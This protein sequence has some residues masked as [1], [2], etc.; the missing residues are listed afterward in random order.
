MNKH[1]ASKIIDT[2]EMY[3]LLK[4]RDR[5][6]LSRSDYAPMVLRATVGRMGTN[7]IGSRIAKLDLFLLLM[8]FRIMW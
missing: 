3:H 4:I 2:F 7:S 8:W 5:S 1:G 6:N